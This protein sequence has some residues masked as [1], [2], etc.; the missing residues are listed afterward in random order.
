M[1]GIP[2]REQVENVTRSGIINWDPTNIPQYAEQSDESFEEQVFAL[3]VLV[4]TID[5]YL[6]STS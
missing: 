1:E 3:K 2:V 5:K 4:S 6:D